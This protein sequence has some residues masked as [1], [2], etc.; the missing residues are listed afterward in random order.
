MPI[1]INI[2]TSLL[3]PVLSSSPMASVL[4]NIYVCFSTEH[5]ALLSGQIHPSEIQQHLPV[6]LVGLRPRAISRFLFNPHCTAV[7]S[8]QSGCN[9]RNTETGTLNIIHIRYI[10]G[11]FTCFISVWRAVKVDFFFS[12][13]SLKVVTTP[14][15]DLLRAPLKKLSTAKNMNPMHR[16]I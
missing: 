3:F 11:Y 8:L 14:T 16:I 4:Y 1:C 7:V 6:P 10:L 9:S 5:I 15:D 12:S 2:L 13:Q